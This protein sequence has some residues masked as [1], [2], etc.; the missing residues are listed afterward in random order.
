MKKLLLAVVMLVTSAVLQAAEVKTFADIPNLRA[1]SYYDFNNQAT[2]FGAQSAIL[3]Y[4]SLDLNVGY[5]SINSKYSGTIAVS[6]N[7]DKLKI[8]N[9][10]YAW[11]NI[12]N[13]DLGVWI[14]YNL[15]D[16][17]YSWGLCVSLV[18]IEK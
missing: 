15:N 4:K 12:I 10:E 1:C 16:K 2:G 11:K 18:T 17:I 14:G 13:T 5:V 3:E 8:A 9:I 7:L 6:V